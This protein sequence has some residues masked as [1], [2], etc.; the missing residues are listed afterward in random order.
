MRR[1]KRAVKSPPSEPHQVDS[2]GK[3]EQVLL[4]AICPSPTGGLREDVGTYLG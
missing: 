1:D 4:A 2:G 3:K